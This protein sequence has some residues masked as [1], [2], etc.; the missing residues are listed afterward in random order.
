MPKIISGMEQNTDLWLEWRKKGLGGS[1]MDTVLNGTEL[2]R[3]HLMWRILSGE[4][5][6]FAPHIVTAME[7][8]H[9]LE[10][11][12]RKLAERA[13]A[14]FFPAVCVESDFDERFRVSLDG[15]SRNGKI[16][17]EVKALAAATH[18]KTIKDYRKTR[19]AQGSISPRY[20]TQI[21]YQ[22]MV[23]DA[24]FA[25][26]AGF[27]PDVPNEAD[28]FYMIPV[29][30]DKLFQANIFEAAKAF[31]NQL[32][33]YRGLPNIISITG[34]AQEGK[35]TIAKYLTRYGY[36]RIG[37]ADSLK[38]EMIDLG[39]LTG[40]SEEEKLNSRQAIVDYS[41]EQKQKFGEDVWSENLIESLGLA[42]TVPNVRIVVPDA[43]YLNEII[44]L[45]HFARQNELTFASWG[46][47]RN[48]KP[49]NEEEAMSVPY[50]LAATDI[51]FDNTQDFLYLH[52]Q[53]EAEMMKYGK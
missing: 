31:F 35:D 53:I 52:S 28:R 48:G 21:Q 10:P 50:A 40:T 44:N 8:G 15:L 43:R 18:L 14:A 41:I 32:D 22:L 30:H 2:E 49:A 29:Q 1:D 24:D 5:L 13:C 42:A 36:N 25:L 11:E 9:R 17:L 47:S 6:H 51:V 45:R 37:H 38:R 27:N 4:K 26:Y 19:S 12:A 46:V 23:A 16:V 33:V 39:F 34:Y 7:R 3:K 20:W